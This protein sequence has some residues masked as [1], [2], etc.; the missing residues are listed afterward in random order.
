M[1]RRMWNDGWFRVQEVQEVKDEVISKKFQV[2]GFKSSRVQGAGGGR[3]DM[4]D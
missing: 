3:G 2:S 4:N 1:T